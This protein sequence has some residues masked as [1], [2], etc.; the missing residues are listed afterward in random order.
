MEKQTLDC[1]NSQPLWK[2]NFLKILFFFWLCHVARGNLQFP[3]RDGTRGLRQAQVLVA[4]LCPTLC[5]PMY[6]ARQAPLSMGFSRR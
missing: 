2:L 3:N 4:R 5:D 1:E 6:A